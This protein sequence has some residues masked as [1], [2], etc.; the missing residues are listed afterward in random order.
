V[1]DCWRLSKLHHIIVNNVIKTLSD[2]GGRTRNPL[3]V[4]VWASLEQML[5]THMFEVMIRPDEGLRA[6]VA[7]DV[8]RSM[9]LRV[10]LVAPQISL[11][12]SSIADFRTEVARIYLIGWMTSLLWLLRLS[13]GLGIDDP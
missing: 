8:C 11:T 9:L 12:P 1:G 2:G 13:D 7:S 10:L 4:F 5:V 3:A 6:H